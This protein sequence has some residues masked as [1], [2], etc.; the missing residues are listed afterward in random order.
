[1]GGCLPTSRAE[2]DQKGV[3]FQPAKRGQ[4]STGVDSSGR[5]RGAS[6]RDKND[7]HDAR[8]SRCPT[9]TSV[10]YHGLPPSCS[11]FRPCES[12]LTVFRGPGEVAHFIHRHVAPVRRRSGIVSLDP[13]QIS[14]PPLCSSDGRGCAVLVA[15][16]IQILLSLDTGHHSHNVAVS[17]TC[18]R[19]CRS[20]RFRP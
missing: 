13:V 8:G 12:T 10:S 20:P 18:Q 1:L 19:P 11:Q 7:Q 5:G 3:S 16:S 6:R 2:T 17:A 15:A 4:L 14:W 9:Q